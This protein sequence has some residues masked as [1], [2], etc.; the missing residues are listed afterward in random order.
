MPMKANF[1]VAYTCVG[2]QGRVGTTTGR[3]D[4]LLS[5]SW[6]SMIQEIN[7]TKSQK[8]CADPSPRKCLIYKHN[9]SLPV[10]F[11]RGK[12]EYVEKIPVNLD[13]YLKDAEIF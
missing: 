3:L 9:L 10:D 7:V 13:K 12:W 6:S 4:H 1:W 11:A 8:L 2:Q 5:N